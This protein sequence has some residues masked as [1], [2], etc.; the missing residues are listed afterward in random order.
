M[1]LLR[2]CPACGSKLLQVSVLK[3]CASCGEDLYA[4]LAS[5]PG[6]P[7]PASSANRQEA[8]TGKNSRQAPLMPEPYYSV[9]LKSNG[10]KEQLTRRLSEVLLRGVLATRMAVEMVPSVLAYKSR[11]KDIQTIIAILEDERAHYAVIKGDLETNTPIKKTFSGISGLGNDQMGILQK[12]PAAMWLGETICMVVSDVYMDDEPGMLVVTDRALYS[13]GRPV[14]TR[15]IEWIIIP[16]VHVLEVLLH[17]DQDEALELVYKDH[18]Q[19]TWF[20]FASAEDMAQV[21]QILHS[22]LRG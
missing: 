13:I 5:N 16:Y 17:T 20:R 7:V 12:V 21:Y 8:E 15:S 18:R 11:A 10:N 19:E 9:V 4:L 2:F 22:T 14:G 6:N 3:Y 1:T